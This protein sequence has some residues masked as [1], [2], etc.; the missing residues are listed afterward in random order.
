MLIFLHVCLG[1]KLRFSW[2][3][4]KHFTNPATYH[5]SFRE[6]DKAKVILQLPSKQQNFKQ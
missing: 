5:T 6:I 4:T 2:L 3:D 1:S